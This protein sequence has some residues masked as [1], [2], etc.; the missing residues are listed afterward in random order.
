MVN[1]R[2]RSTG[3]PQHSIH[4]HPQ[5]SERLRRKRANHLANHQARA[6]VNTLRSKSP[7]NNPTW[8]GVGKHAGVNGNPK[9]HVPGGRIKGKKGKGEERK[10]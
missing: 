7:L 2:Q 9:Q 6:E 10:N 4:P 1:Q 8:H 3:D 5:P